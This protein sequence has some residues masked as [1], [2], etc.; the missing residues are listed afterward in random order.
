MGAVAAEGVDR[1]FS[2]HPNEQRCT[3]GRGSCDTEA[4]LACLR[5]V[6]SKKPAQLGQLKSNAMSGK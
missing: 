4:A 5:A 1:P 3:H 2:G 6:L